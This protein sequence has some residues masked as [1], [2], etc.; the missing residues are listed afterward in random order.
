MV[1]SWRGQGGGCKSILGLDFGGSAPAA[2][3]YNHEKADLFVYNAGF[4]LTRVQNVGVEPK[5][6]QNGL[7]GA[8][9]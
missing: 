3:Y 2:L 7:V 5:I 4:E 8:E 1:S 6:I 9:I